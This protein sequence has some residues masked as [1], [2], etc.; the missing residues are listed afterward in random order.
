MNTQ[1]VPELI[2]W[3]TPLNSFSSSQLEFREIKLGKG[4][5][6][7]F[8]CYKKDSK[9]LIHCKFPSYECYRGTDEGYDGFFSEITLGNIKPK[10]PAFALKNTNWIKEIINDPMYGLATPINGKPLYHFIICTASEDFEVLT[11]DFP[12]FE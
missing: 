1:D 3:D 11:T 7:P 5:T 10:G 8:E 2:D 12:I 4:I 9:S 6:I